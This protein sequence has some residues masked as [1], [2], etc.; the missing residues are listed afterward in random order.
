[1]LAELCRG[2]LH[3]QR[4]RQHGAGLRRRHEARLWDAD[5]GSH[6]RLGFHG[7]SAGAGV[8]CRD[9][10]LSFLTGLMIINRLHAIH[11]SPSG[12]V[13]FN[14]KYDPLVAAVKAATETG[15][16]EAGI[17][18]RDWIRLCSRALEVSHTDVHLS[19]YSETL[20]LLTLYVA[21]LKPYFP[22]LP[23]SSAL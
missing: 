21:E 13:H 14:P 2:A 18:G 16:K 19:T 12:Q 22:F 3:A 8:P 7:E 9:E 6:R 1:M 23:F 10:M 15:V 17:D 4:G 20:A 11:P 5:W